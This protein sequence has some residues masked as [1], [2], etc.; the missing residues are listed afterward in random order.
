LSIFG[1]FENAPAISR[2]KAPGNLA[3]RDQ[4]AA[5]WWVRKNIASFGGNPSQV[6]IFGESAGAYS[7]RALLSA[8]SAFGLYRNV[9]SMSDL[10]GM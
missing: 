6:T 1:L 9:I 4:I 2:R 10:M 7:M 8:P 5:L 3:V